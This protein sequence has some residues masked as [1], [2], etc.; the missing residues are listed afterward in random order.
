[1]RARWTA[2]VRCDVCCSDAPP[3]RFHGF[4]RG[5]AA[6]PDVARIRAAIYRQIAVAYALGLRD[7]ADE[8][9]DFGVAPDAQLHLTIQGRTP[10]KALGLATIRT[11]ELSS[12]LATSKP[13]IM[14]TL[15]NFMDRSLPGAVGLKRSGA[16]GTFL[17]TSQDR[18]RHRM[19]ELTDNDTS[20]PIVVVGYSSERF[21]GYNLA[22]RLVNLGYTKV[23]WYRGGRETWEARG[24]PEANLVPQDW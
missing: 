11:D 6:S 19:P 9:A 13:L 21:D 7:Q 5:L 14:D 16:G 3:N 1:M 10:T 15:W 17:D 12:M 23:Y 18:L 2:C 24:L 4:Q 8:D 20:M 22:L